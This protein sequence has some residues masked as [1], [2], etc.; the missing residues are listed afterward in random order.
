MSDLIVPPNNLDA[1]QSVIGALLSDG[2]R[3]DDLDCSAEDFYLHV[4]KLI[5]TAIKDLHNRNLNIDV[6]SVAEELES[7]GELKNI[8]GLGY[9][10]EITR[11]TPVTAN[12][13]Q[14]ANI[15]REKSLR[16]ELIKTSSEIAKDAFNST[17]TINDIVASAESK[18]YAIG[19]KHETHE[20]VS[21]SVAVDEALEHL[22]NVIDGLTYLSTGLTD[23]DEIIG[24]LRGGAT[25]VIAARSSMG[26]TAL[27]CS[28]AHSVAKTTPCYI[29]TLEMPRRE[30]A[31]RLMAIHGNLN[32]G[33]AKNWTAD[34]YNKLTVASSV[35]NAMPITIDHEESLKITKLRARCRRLKRKKNIG[36][37]FV[38]YLQ[39]MKS[40]AD[41]RE[42]EIAQISEG[43]K[44]LLK[45]L[46]SQLL[47]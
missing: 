37:I 43:L 9:L 31:A 5:F 10:I 27:L 29:A 20:P 14:Y 46:M 23:L 47:F 6:V 16:R 39:L 34:D 7:I 11:N 3:I 26:K 38:D 18:I 19:D 36:C 8:G 28:I 33:D 42:R 22:G 45:S 30:I 1:E 21:I 35:I 32:L 40:K 41:G 44:S 13:K 4:N 2:W 15:V 17:D 24:G 25:Y 12:L